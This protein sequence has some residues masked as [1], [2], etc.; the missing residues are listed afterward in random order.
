M[1]ILLF[2]GI[3]YLLLNV[4]LFRLFP[5][6][7][8]PAFNGFI[9][10]I[11]FISWNKIIGRKP[12]YTLWLLFPIVNIFVYAGMC[13]DLARS[14]GRYTFLDSF[15]AVVFGPL[16]FILLAGKANYG[17]P[18]LK[19]EQ[20]FYHKYQ[21]AKEKNDQVQLRKLDQS[22]PYKKGPIREWAEA[23][24]FAVFAAAFIRMFLIEAY[25]IPT[26]SMEGSLLTGDFL[27]V[28]KVHYGVRT[29][30]TIAMLPLL[31]NQVPLIGGESY[32]KKPS[33]PYFRFPGWEKIKRNDPVVFNYPEGDSVIITPNRTYS[34]MDLKRNNS[35][36]PNFNPDML[37]VRPMDKKDHYIKRC[38]GLPGDTL[39][40]KDRQVYIQGKPVKNPRFMQFRYH[41]NKPI[42]RSRLEQIG[43]NVNEM[44]A[45]NNIVNLDEQMVRQIQNM[46]S[47]VQITVVPSPIES[48]R[49]YL[50]PND[51]RITSTW[52]MDNYGPIYIPKKG[53]TVNLTIENLP[54]Y[55]RIIGV[56]EGN[57]LVVKDNKIFINGTPAATYTFKMDYYWMMGDN[58]H[59]SEDSRV[60]GFVPEDHVVGKPLFIWLSAKAAS[61]KNGIRWKRMF[62][63]A[64][65]FAG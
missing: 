34:F 6:A 57:E 43:V 62:T 45:T 32:L 3:G 17:G 5:K 9:P 37:I 15:L 55:Q 12:A 29:P 63:S 2:F 28:S 25:V 61:I 50:F 41:L 33:L 60:W 36:P 23:I 49:P 7:N 16:Y 58:R 51:I 30:Q 19:Q 31:H 18:V 52:S 38:I 14:F 64:N 53:T 24:I 1:G 8:I 65:K 42:N 26:S 56:Y 27:F 40:V 54:Y 44:D 46:D 48:T 22:N 4:G 47:E 10:G 21:A 59:N 35:L 13:V 20:E 39:E 11:N